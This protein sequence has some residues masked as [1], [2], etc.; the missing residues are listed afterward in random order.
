MLFF[1]EC[2]QVKK[3][4]SMGVGTKENEKKSST[5]ITHALKVKLSRAVI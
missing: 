3:R 4:E 1:I 2:L 5:N